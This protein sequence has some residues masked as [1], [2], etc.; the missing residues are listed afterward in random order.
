[1]YLGSAGQSALLRLP[2]PAKAPDASA[3]TRLEGLPAGRAGTIATLKRMKELA[4]AAVRAPDQSI[5][6][7]AISIFH[8]EGIPPRAYMREADALQRFVRDAIR[9]LRDP[10]NLEL[11]QAPQRTLEIG[12]GDCDDKATLLASMLLATGKPARFLALGF[13]GGPLSH[14]LVEMKSG[15]RWIPMET[16]LPGK[17]MGW[18]PPNATSR[19]VYN[20]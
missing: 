8:D 9:Y 4:R 3:H 7:R 18:M 20:L 19:Y 2:N 13:K 10:V 6:N 12:A 17:P 16:I 14:V 15:N 5:R 11:V 1:M